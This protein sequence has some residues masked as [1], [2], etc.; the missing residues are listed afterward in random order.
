MGAAGQNQNDYLLSKCPIFIFHH[1]FVA[2]ERDKEAP[3]AKGGSC[4]V[5]L[6]IWVTPTRIGG[7]VHSI[8]A[9]IKYKAC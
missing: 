9:P 7:D 8:G 6:G 5:G 2:S 1:F 4:E 3:V